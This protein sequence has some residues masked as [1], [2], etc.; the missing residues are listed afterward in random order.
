MYYYIILFHFNEMN[1]LSFYSYDLKL[2]QLTV[3][4][5]HEININISFKKFKQCKIMYIINV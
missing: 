2:V 1:S 4:S 5:G 3:C